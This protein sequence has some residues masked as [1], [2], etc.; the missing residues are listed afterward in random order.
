MQRIKNQSPANNMY[1]LS[2]FD[3]VSF[4]ARGMLWQSYPKVTTGDVL[5]LRNSPSP[6]GYQDAWLYYFDFTGFEVPHDRLACVST[7][8][9]PGVLV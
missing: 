7:P 6:G 2:I 3:Y 8:K 4:A 5:P 9:C 1:I